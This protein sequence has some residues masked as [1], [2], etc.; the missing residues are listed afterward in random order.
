[1][2]EFRGEHIVSGGPFQ[3]VPEELLLLWPAEP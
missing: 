1:M 3:T 2:D